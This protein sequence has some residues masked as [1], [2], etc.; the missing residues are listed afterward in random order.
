MEKNMKKN[1]YLCTT[2]SLCWTVE[3][4][5]IVNQLY[6]NKINLKKTHKEDPPKKIPKEASQPNF[7]GHSQQT[8]PKSANEESIC[9]VW[10]V[11]HFIAQLPCPLRHH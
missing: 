11:A 4:N 5:N 9:S 7:Q 6:L 3:I 10:A 8:F 2:E 1:V